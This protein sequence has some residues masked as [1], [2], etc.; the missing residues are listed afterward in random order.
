MLKLFFLV[1]LISHLLGDFYFQ[2]DKLAHMKVEKYKFLLLHSL[3]YLVVYVTFILPFWSFPLFLGAIILAASHYI[4]DSLKYILS[5]KYGDHKALFFIDQL[6]H[7]ACI[8]TASVYLTQAGY[9]VK[10]LPLI[11]NALSPVIINYESIL[12]WIGLILLLLKP[13]NITIMQFTR[14]YRP[15]KTNSGSNDNVNEDI[16]TGY[17]NAG[18]LIGSLERLLIALLISVGQYAA[19]GLVLTAK[20]VAR[21]NKIAE[22]KQFAEYYLLGTLTSTLYAI[23]AYFVIFRLF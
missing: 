10:L 15:M 11:T 14:K 5:K 16:S 2:S 13:A 18:A 7:I 6:L 17:D 19:I 3:L 23:L 12:M 1:F 22:D 8:F 4:I 20:S 9:E 21:Y